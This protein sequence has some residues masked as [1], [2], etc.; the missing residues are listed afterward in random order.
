MTM[1]RKEPVIFLLY[2]GIRI[3]SQSDIMILFHNKGIYKEWKL[4]YNISR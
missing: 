4:C 3:Q 2:L 1:S